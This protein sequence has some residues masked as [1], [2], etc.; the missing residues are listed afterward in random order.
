MG[1]EEKTLFNFQDNH[2]QTFQWLYKHY[3]AS[4]TIYLLN[5]VSDKQIAEDLVQETFLKLWNKRKKLDIKGSFKNYLFRS[6]YNNMIDHQ[7]E[8]SKNRDMLNQHILDASVFYEDLDDDYKEKMLLKLEEC[9]E[10]LPEKCK[11]IFVLIKIKK[12]RYKDVEREISIS[13]KTIE[14]H[15]RR[16]YIFLKDCVNPIA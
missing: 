2:K 12:L 9:I 3:Y 4:L 10:L 15:I 14:G 1:N 8:V 16:A 6:A 11:N 5:F 13:Q 7:R